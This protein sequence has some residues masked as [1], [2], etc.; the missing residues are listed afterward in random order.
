MTVDDMDDPVCLMTE[1]EALVYLAMLMSSARGLFNEPADYGP[2]RLVTAMQDLV[3]IALPRVQGAT[4]SLLLRL[5][6]GVKDH[7]PRRR[8]EPDEW[9]QFI[10]DAKRWIAREML[11]RRLDE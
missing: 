4:R 7:L 9:L 6:E 1:E 3:R 10:D 8:S 5:D 2:M 11:E